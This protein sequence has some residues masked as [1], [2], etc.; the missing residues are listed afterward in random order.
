M[1]FA[2]FMREQ[3]APIWA[4]EQAHPFVRGIA[5]GSLPPEKFKFYMIQD[6]LYLIDYSRVFALAAA[7]AP[8]LETMGRF[9]TLL[10]ETLATEMDLHRSYAARFGATAAEF[11]QARPAP[12]TVAYTKHML[13]VAHA[14]TIADIV[15]VVLPCQWG[16]AE[17]G[18]HLAQVGDTSDANPYADWIRMYSSPEFHA[19][20]DWLRGLIDRLAAA[21][22][23]ADRQRWQ[24]Y[25]LTSSRHEYMFWEMAWHGEAW[26]V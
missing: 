22:P 6:Y 3:A 1:S 11:E 18:R 12:T 25:F 4:Q 15:A 17:I 23:A 16:Y 10:H 20:G 7:K 5:D 2:A 19:L 9:S 13:W 24:E 8:D 14:G 26:P 21:A